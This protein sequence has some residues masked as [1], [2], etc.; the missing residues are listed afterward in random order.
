ME[1]ISRLKNRGQEEGEGGEGEKEKNRSE[2]N[3]VKAKR[4]EGNIP[5]MSEVDRRQI[6]MLSSL[7]GLINVSEMTVQYNTLQ[8]YLLE[9]CQDAT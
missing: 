1:A 8:H 3:G 2:G 5:P 7:T 6:N 4:G 9:S